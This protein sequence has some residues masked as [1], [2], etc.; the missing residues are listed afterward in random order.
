MGVKLLVRALQPKGVVGPAPYDILKRLVD[1]LCASQLPGRSEAW[2][3]TCQ[4]LKQ[5]HGLVGTVGG[6]AAGVGGGLKDM[7]VVS[8]R[9]SPDQAFLL[10]RPEFKV[11]ECEAAVMRLLE[12]KLEFAKQ[13]T[14]R[15]EGH[16]YSKGD[17]LL[18]LC[19]A[20]QAIH[21]TQALLGHCLEVEYLPLSSLTTSEAMMAEFVDLMRQLLTEMGAGMGMGMAGDGGGGGGRQGGGGGGTALQL[22]V[23]KPSFDKYGIANMPYSRTHA[24]VAYSDL[25]VAMLNT[26][27]AAAA[28]A[29][30]AQQQPQQQYQQQPP[31]YQQPQYQQHPQQQQPP[32]QQQYQQ[33]QQQQQLGVK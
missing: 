2:S 28:A 24:A 31:Q 26:S 16:T 13:M 25:V 8:F 11:L 18:R 27:A 30:A 7:W 15:F 5:G 32:Q 22:E 20:T 17:F 1:E 12:K 3:V 19:T 9:D 33:Q 21:S 6:P 23:L 29:A 14:V 4:L 10:M